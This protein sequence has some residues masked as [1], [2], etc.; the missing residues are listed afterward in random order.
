MGGPGQAGGFLLPGG[1]TMPGQDQL[2][3]ASCASLTAA[4]EHQTRGQLPALTKRF[5]GS[6]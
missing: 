6:P 4:A 2:S 1:V 3:E 5:M